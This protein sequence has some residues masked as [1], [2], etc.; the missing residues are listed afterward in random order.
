MLKWWFFSTGCVGSG[1]A[2]AESLSSDER[3]D[4]PDSSTATDTVEEDESTDTSTDALDAFDGIQGA[5]VTADCRYLDYAYAI[6]ILL[7]CGSERFG[8]EL[9][10]H[11]FK[12]H[13]YRHGQ[14]FRDQRLTYREGQLWFDA[15]ATPRCVWIDDRGRLQL[16][17]QSAQ[18][19]PIALQATGGGFY[20]QDTSTAQCAGLG[21]AVCEEHEWTGG[22]ECG[23]ID[24]RFLPLV[25]GD[26]SEALKFTLREE[27]DAC[28]DEYPEADCF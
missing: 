26:C 25:M 16:T 1:S 11:T 7:S 4:A 22:R 12:R 24:H 3:P 10:L 2:P 20:I 8:E 17:T 28:A 15:Y 27:A 19:A 5:L 21:T 18:C 23:G 6:D 14:I 9:R 13:A